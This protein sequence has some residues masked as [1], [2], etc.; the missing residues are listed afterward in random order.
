MGIVR[1]VSPRTRVSLVV[2]AAALAAAALAIGVAVVQSDRDASADDADGRRLRGAPPL[3]LDLG[4]RTDAE[5]RALRRAAALHGQGRRSAAAR[6]F[7]RYDSLQARI[8]TAVTSWPEGTVSTL[9]RLERTHRRSGLVRLN[10]GI[11]LLWAGRREAAVDRWRAARQVDPDSLAAI[12]ADDLLHP[13]F[14]L[15][16]RP[17]FVPSFDVPEGIAALPPPRRVAALAARARRGGARA[18]IL[19]G[20]ALQRLGRPLSA[21]REFDAALALA[22]SDPDAHVAAA[23]ARFEKSR[24]RVAFARLGPLTRRF[25]RS[26][27]VRFHLGLLLLWLGDLDAARRQLTLAR[28]AGP[29]TPPGR[30]AARVLRRLANN[31]V[32]RD[33][34]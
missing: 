16:G 10:L 12:R 29:A 30:E 15:T 8:G 21:R 6:I 18:K 2:A 27:S 25:P 19:Y 17:V 9:A 7:R 4:V 22:P 31:N 23:V 1:Q 32:G 24:P 33:A 20:V 3:V 26:A 34:Y 5:A 11:A 14:P 28:A 13:R